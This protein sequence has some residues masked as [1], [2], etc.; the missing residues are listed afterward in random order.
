MDIKLLKFTF[1]SFD[2]NPSNRFLYERLLDLDR[3]V[4]KPLIEKLITKEL[5]IEDTRPIFSLFYDYGFMQ[6]KLNRRQQRYKALINTNSSFINN[7]RNRIFHQ[8]DY[9]N[10]T[11][12]END[13]YEETKKFVIE[14]YEVTRKEKLTEEEKR[15][16]ILALDTMIHVDFRTA[17][18]RAQRIIDSIKPGN[19][20]YL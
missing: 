1:D 9:V 18:K 14:S 8:N 20:T 12:I 10:E 3:S 16:I 17:G 2:I 13:E 11:Y 19:S 7:L 4:Y 5:D 6:K 15:K